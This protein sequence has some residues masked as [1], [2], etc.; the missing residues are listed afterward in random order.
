MLLSY[1]YKIVFANVVFSYFSDLKTVQNLWTYWKVNFVSCEIFYFFVADVRTLSR[2]LLGF[3]NEENMVQRVQRDAE[4]W[5]FLSKLHGGQQNNE[6]VVN[7]LIAILFVSQFFSSRVNSSSDPNQLG[8]VPII[9]SD[10]YPRMTRKI[11]LNILRHS[12][13]P[14]L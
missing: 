11:F 7:W 1:C 9:V 6:D 5:V 2:A 8:Y 3:A 13:V 14:V 10:P 4:K 12:L